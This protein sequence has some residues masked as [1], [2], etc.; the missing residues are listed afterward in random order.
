MKIAHG[1]MKMKILDT[2]QDQRRDL[3]GVTWSIG[4]P[5]R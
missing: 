2:V 5:N 1:D 4:G 3:F